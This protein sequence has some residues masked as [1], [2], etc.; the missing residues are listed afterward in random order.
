[1]SIFD[2]G[3]ADDFLVKPMAMP[4]AFG[5]PFVHMGNYSVPDKFWHIGELERIETLQMEI[6]KTHSALVNDRKG[7]QRK[8]MVMEDFLNDDGPNSLSRVLRSEDDNLIAS[9]P[10]LQ[11]GQRMEDII[12][13][14][15]SP[16]LDPALY[17]VGT[18]LQNLMNEVSGIS[19]YQRGSGAGSG[20]ATE[21][22]IINDGTLARMKEKQGK[23][24]KLMR[25][26]ARR[27]VM[28]KQQ[29]MKSEKA[30]RISMGD[31]PQS[32]QKL[33]DAGVDLESATGI[34]DPT[35][36]FTT[37]TAESIRGEYDIVVEAGSS[38]AFN[39]TQRRRSIQE[40]LATIGPFLQLGKIDVD[41]L[42]TYVLRFGF[43]IPNASEFLMPPP[44]PPPEAAGGI[45]Y[46]G[47]VPPG[48][49]QGLPP[50][51]G[52]PSVAG[53]VLQPAGGVP[54]SASAPPAY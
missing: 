4:F 33:S 54:E 20:T 10:K 43:G 49:G 8:W 47:P 46:G 26:S 15:P 19:D 51:G 28:L 37:Y 21:A 9:I 40:M 13:R 17:S 25:D 24:E 27:L 16:N 39:E 53:G 32:A 1:M 44:P 22:A 3:M 48:Q 5:H 6:N 11:S 45:P 31:N 35:E 12:S 52:V 18:V 36:L 41:A 7:F 14:V 42:L 38:T 23:I 29:Y 34:A 2:E 30:L 50:G